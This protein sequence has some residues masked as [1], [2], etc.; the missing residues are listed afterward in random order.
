MACMLHRVYENLYLW[1][2]VEVYI[3]LYEHKHYAIQHL[4]VWHDIKVSKLERIKP[5]TNKLILSNKVHYLSN[6]VCHL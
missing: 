5:N 3:A 4:F 6:C 2:S 1:Q